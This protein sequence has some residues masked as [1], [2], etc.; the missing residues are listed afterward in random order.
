MAGKAGLPACLPGII[1]C[2][3]DLNYFFPQNDRKIRVY[4]DLV[5]RKCQKNEYIRPL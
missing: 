5:F 1:K 2:Q 3:F 4:L